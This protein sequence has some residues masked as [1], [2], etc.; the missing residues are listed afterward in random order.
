MVE[1]DPQAAGRVIGALTVVAGS[2]HIV[3]TLALILSPALA[4]R[5]APG[6]LLPVGPAEL[7]LALWLAAK[8]VQAR[9]ARRLADRAPKHRHPASVMAWWRRLL[10]YPGHYPTLLAV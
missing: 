4:D 3:N 2:G 5:L 10:Y 6:I 7:S 9:P 8:G 1:G